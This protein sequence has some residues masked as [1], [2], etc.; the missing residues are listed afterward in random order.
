M[1]ETIDTAKEIINIKRDIREIKQSQEAG[2]HFNREQYEKLV[3]DALMG[4]PTRVKV[5][6]EV[7]GIKSRKEIQTVLG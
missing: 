6:L 1:P 5:F 3:S 7:D 4:N 2:M